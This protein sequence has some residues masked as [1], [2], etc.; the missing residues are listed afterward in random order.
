MKEVK[1]EA[2]LQEEVNSA[3]IVINWIGQLFNQSFYP[4]TKI[5]ALE[6]IGKLARRLPFQV[7]LHQALPYIAKVF[8]SQSKGKEALSHSRVKVKGLEVL[9]SIFSDII[10]A[11]DIIPIEPYDFLVFQNYIMPLIK[12]LI[13]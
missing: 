6:M 8:T 1:S 13:D 12:R 2:G 5:I 4:Q 11:T 10:D 7:R 9:L 3:M